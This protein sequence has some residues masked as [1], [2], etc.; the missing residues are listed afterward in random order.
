MYCFEFNKSELEKCKPIRTVVIISLR[1]EIDQCAL[2][3]K[4]EYCTVV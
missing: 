2:T 4:K 3:T 1:T